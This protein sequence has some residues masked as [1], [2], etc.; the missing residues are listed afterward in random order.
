VPQKTCWGAEEKDHRQP[1]DPGWRADFRLRRLRWD[2]TRGVEAA[3]KYAKRRKQFGQPISE[4]SGHQFKL[5][6]M[7]SR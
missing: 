1:E 4:F 3:T 6:D 5:A 2:G 7:A